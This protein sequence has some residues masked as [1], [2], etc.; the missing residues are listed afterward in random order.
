MSPSST[1]ESLR[2]HAI[3]KHPDRQL[4]INLTWSS[5]A[6]SKSPDKKP[7]IAEVNMQHKWKPCHRSGHMRSSL[8]RHTQPDISCTTGC[9]TC[10]MT[11]D[12]TS[13]AGGIKPEVSILH[14]SI[15]TCRTRI[16]QYISGPRPCLPLLQSR[17][18]HVSLTQII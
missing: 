12:Q 8:W 9:I 6:I 10:S 16:C 3:S 14:D 2:G 1:R 5:H 15:A 11:W 17:L 13:A 4:E 18:H 7:S